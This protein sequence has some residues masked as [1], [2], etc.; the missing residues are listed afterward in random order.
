MVGRAGRPQFDTEGMA[1]IM[2]Q[3]QVSVDVD[4]H[5]GGNIRL[6]S[7]SWLMSSLDALHAPDLPRSARAGPTHLPPRV[8]TT[9]R[10]MCAVT[11]S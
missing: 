1:V 10:S 7:C 5:A 8:R 2:T 11:S 3:K 6:G 4:S 9:A